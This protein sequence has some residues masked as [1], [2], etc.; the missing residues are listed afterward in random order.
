M[1]NSFIPADTRNP[2]RVN[3]AEARALRFKA[4]LQALQPFKPDFAI[5]LHRMYD[6]HEEFALAVEQYFRNRAMTGI[7]DRSRVDRILPEFAQAR[8]DVLIAMGED[9]DSL[10]LLPAVPGV[11]AG[12]LHS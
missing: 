11:P 4:R 3:E 9:P 6:R 1:T 8:R 2:A 7:E 12:P 5:T 10:E